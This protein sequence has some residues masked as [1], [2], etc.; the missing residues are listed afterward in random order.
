MKSSHQNARWVQEREMPG[1]YGMRLTMRLQR[2]LGRRFCALLLYP[3]VA[4]YYPFA[5]AARQASQHYAQHLQ[6]TAQAQGINLPHFSSYCHILH[7]ARAMLDK[8]NAWQGLLHVGRDLLYTPGSRELLD[9]ICD[10]GQ[11]CLVLTSHLG[12]IEACRAL[13]EEHRHI[14]L[15]AVVFEHNAQ[16]FAQVMAHY[17][18]KSRLNLIDAATVGPELAISLADKLSRGEWLA[19]AADRLPPHGAERCLQ[20]NFL[21]ARAAFA[22]GPFVLA[23]LFDVPVVQLFGCRQGK[24]IYFSALPLA[25]QKVTRRS[26]RLAAQQALCQAYCANLE[27]MALR[28]P[29]E[30][31]NFFDFWQPV[32]GGVHASHRTPSH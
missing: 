4:A 11:G 6:H 28:Y 17:V 3:I 21:G 32:D 23:Q 2:L 27:Q 13:I 26:E 19:I 20:A 14:V 15:N 12:N 31:F 5:R 24:H 18:P 16:G 9:E 1:M 10:K 7:F 29:Y 30:W 8:L 25:R 22:Q